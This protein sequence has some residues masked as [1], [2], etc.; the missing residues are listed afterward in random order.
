MYSKQGEERRLATHPEYHQMADKL[1]TALLAR[2][3]KALMRWNR[4]RM[5]TEFARA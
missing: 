1:E 3:R 2:K 4:S 5:D